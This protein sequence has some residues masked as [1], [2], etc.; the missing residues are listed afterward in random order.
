MVK[1]LYCSNT[2]SSASEM[3]QCAEFSFNN[4]FLRTSQI[5][6]ATKIADLEN[7]SITAFL[8]RKKD[9]APIMSIH[10]LKPE[11]KKIKYTV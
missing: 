5:V 8:S 1:Y 7:I 10:S 11:V 3:F 9:K 6:E 2:S 4:P